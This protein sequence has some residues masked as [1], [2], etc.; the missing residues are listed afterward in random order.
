MGLKELLL[1]CSVEF[2]RTR[3]AVE[4]KYQLHRMMLVL[5]LLVDFPIGKLSEVCSCPGST[6]YLASFIIL[7]EL[8]GLRTIPR[9]K[10][11]EQ[12]SQ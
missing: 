8:C 2:F 9:S 1:D 3:S 4:V 11:G 7:K 6:C 5:F 10:S 12:I